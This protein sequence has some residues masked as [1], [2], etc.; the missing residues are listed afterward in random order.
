MT[1][2]AAMANE[3]L[4]ARL[5]ELNENW[6]GDW[7]E[8]AEM[9]EISRI[10]KTRMLEENSKLPGRLPSSKFLGAKYSSAINISASELKVGDY[11]NYAKPGKTYGDY[12]ECIELTTDEISSV[13]TTVR[14]VWKRTN[15]QDFQVVSADYSADENLNIVRF[16][17]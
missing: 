7:S 14:T 13:V 10:L 12:Y 17:Y 1:D 2:Y 6:N 8:E 3:E 9:E 11:A 4:S 15:T 5:E 16:H